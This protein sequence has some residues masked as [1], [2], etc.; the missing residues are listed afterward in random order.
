MKACVSLLVGAILLLTGCSDQPTP[1][2]PD[3]RMR[4]IG[5]AR[6]GLHTDLARAV[7]LTTTAFPHTARLGTAI[8]GLQ[9]AALDAWSLTGTVVPALDDVN[10][11]GRLTTDACTAVTNPGALT[12]RIALAERGTCQFG[13]KALNVQEAGAVALIVYSNTPGVV[14]MGGDHPLVTIP[15]FLIERPDGLALRAAPVTV[16]LR[17]VELV[18]PV[19][20]ERITAAGQFT[21]ALSPIPL[22]NC[23]GVNHSGNVTR[24]ITQ[25]YFDQRATHAAVTGT[26]IS[27]STGSSH[28]CGLRSDGAL[29]CWGGNSLG[30]VNRIPSTES[31]YMIPLAVLD[32]PPGMTY[33]QLSAGDVHT[34]AMR[35]DGALECW[36]R[37]AWG[38]VSM[39]P[40]TSEPYFASARLTD[41]D[42]VPPAAVSAGHLFT[43]VLRTDRLVYCWGDD[44]SGKSSGTPHTYPYQGLHHPVGGGSGFV[45]VSAGTHHACALEDIGRVHCWGSNDNGEAPDTRGPQ[46]GGPFVKVTAGHGHSCALRADGAIECWGSNSHGQAPPLR[47]A[48]ASRYVDL[49]AG[50]LFEHDMARTCAVRADQ[51]IECWGANRY[52]ESSPPAIDPI[53]PDPA[54]PNETPVGDDVSVTPTD[55]TTGEPSPVALTFDNV[56]EAG[57]TTVTSGSVGGGSGPPPPSN[58]RLGSPPTYYNVKTTASYDGSITVCLSYAGVTYGNEN[59]LK[60]LHGET[61]AS[62]NVTWVNVTTSLD[63]ENDI[64]CG[65]VTSLS[66]FLAAELNAAPVVTGIALPGAPVPVGTAVSISATFTDVNP[67]DA[68]TAIIDWEDGTGVGAAAGGSLTGTHTYDRAGV[69][70]IGVTVSDGDLAGTRNSLADMPAYIVVFDPAGGFVTGGG[71]IMSPAGALAADGSVTGKA[72]FGFVSRYRPGATVPSGDTEFHFRAGA[73]QFRSSAYEWLVVSGSRAQF[74]G[75]G[76]VNGVGSHRFMITAIDGGQ[77]GFDRFRIRIWNATGLVYDN[78]TGEPEDSDASTALGGGS[79]VIHKP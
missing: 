25:V 5:P 43:C 29:E 10:D 26:Y 35:S 75:E 62:G 3:A 51:V 67:L 40:G 28:A 49:S 16:H 50:G 77:D 18:Q 68:H 54:D 73:L 66:P 27:V 11:A 59:Q 65:T 74:R 2:E 61:D 41:I 13:T 38:E 15:V 4:H 17:L 46:G 8:F 45:Q 39:T 33:T 30:Q 23:F 44:R 21:C 48:A 37:N 78:A 31:P 55:E 9:V 14:D 56:T 20:G 71:W 12:G 6:A 52:G 36:G 63:T 60:L 57:S 79:V 47:T 24:T 69:Y 53:P 34:C 58:F 1:F 70:T 19:T 22:I 42:G 64:I 72:T 32:P 76:S 7:F